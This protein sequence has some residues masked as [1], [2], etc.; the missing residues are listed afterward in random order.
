MPLKNNITF[1][2]SN[3]NKYE[4]VKAILGSEIVVSRCSLDLVEI[5][6]NL[7]D[8]CKFKCRKAALAVRLHYTER[9]FLRYHRFADLCSSMIRPC[10]LVH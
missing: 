2:T 4:E 7:Q 10:H 5:Q 6:G 9:K 8:I 3:D 1:L